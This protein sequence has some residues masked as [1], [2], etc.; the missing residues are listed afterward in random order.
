MTAHLNVDYT[1]HPAGGDG[2]VRFGDDGGEFASFAMYSFILNR[3][4]VAA[5]EPVPSP[6]QT[7]PIVDGEL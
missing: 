2:D 4:E 7:R 5:L 6:R 1:G 3:A